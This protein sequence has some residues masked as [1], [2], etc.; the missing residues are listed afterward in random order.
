MATTFPDAPMNQP[1]PATPLH[2]LQTVFGYPSFWGEQE[3]VIAHVVAGGEA[4]VIMPT[5][6]GKSLCYQ[7]PSLLR[8]GVGVVVSPLIALMR[9]QVL[10]LRGK[11]VRAAALN[12]SLDYA[13]AQA[14]EQQALRGDLDLLYVAPERVTTDRML[15]LLGQM[16]VALFAIDEAHCVSQ[17][18]HDF[19]P[20]YLGLSVLHQRFPDVPRLALTATADQR[21]REE[22]ITRLELGAG[23]AFIGG[24]DRPNIRY[25][26]VPKRNSKRVLWE[27]LERK[28]PDD[29]GIVYCLSRRKTEQIATWITKQG[30][31][32]VPYH[33]GLDA[34]TRRR[35][36]DRFLHERG[37][38][39]V[40][41]IAFGLG[42]DKPDIRFVAH[43]DLPKSVEAYYQ[44]TGRAG[45][46]GLPADAWMAFGKGDLMMQRQFILESEAD[47]PHKRLALDK[48]RSLVRLCETRSCR[49]KLLLGYFGEEYPDQ[50]GNCDNCGAEPLSP[51]AARGAHRGRP[52]RGDA[53]P[54]F[55]RRAVPYNELWEALRALRVG[56]AKKGGI[57]AYCVFHDTTL[58]AMAGRRPQDLESLAEISGVGEAK[59]RKYGEAFLEVLR[60][61]QPAKSAPLSGGKPRAAQHLVMENPA[62]GFTGNATAP[63]LPPEAQPLWEA[64][65][66]ARLALA[67]EVGGMAFSVYPDSVLRTMAQVQ[68]LTL[69]ALAR[70]RG[71]E[72]EMMAPYAEGMLEV[73]RRLGARRA[74]GETPAVPGGSTGV[75][76][77][78][79]GETPVPL[80]EAPSLLQVARELRRNP[81]A[82]EAVLWEALGGQRLGFKFRRQH[83]LGEMIV[84]FYCPVVKV[85]VLIGVD[86][87][88]DPRAS[89]LRR[90]G[91]LV[92]EIKDTQVEQETEAT[93]RLI[94]A[95]CLGAQE[96]REEQR[97]K[98][99]DKV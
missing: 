94:R 57:P 44:E 13:E 1:A 81:T 25:T 15:H 91:L 51:V 64:L 58:R 7:I 79:T 36:Q 70:V 31:T 4:L 86:G 67:R 88:V 23:R 53:P 47:E 71:R 33:A 11:G 80:E 76:G 21:T 46:D 69:E 37:L 66:E 20:D 72:P 83:P 63:P 38:I 97:W 54:A 85:A 28:H 26:I 41:T 42:I 30:R 18:G 9:D 52:R 48:L 68:P 27:W 82:A 61:T 96:E 89:E 8:P 87:Q 77:E 12:S 93:L 99:W 19:R 98:D 75:P 35:H 24:F 92:L 32:A 50:C 39:V 65:R 78:S 3:A 62:P 34:S 49:R 5:G 2:L 17:W 95:V 56:L 55:P 74:A 22:I 16:P 6:G 60:Q 43:L 84:D 73:L 40:A 29:A 59:L 10:A 45:R 90:Q 14:I